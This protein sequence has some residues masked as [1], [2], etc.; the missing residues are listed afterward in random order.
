M[1]A[2]GVGREAKDEMHAVSEGLLGVGGPYR[3][4]ENMGWV[5]TTN[6]HQPQPFLS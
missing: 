3:D 1:H 2:S 4:V 6:G 5:S